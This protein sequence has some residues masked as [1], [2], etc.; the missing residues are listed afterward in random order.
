MTPKT[1]TCD[2][3]KYPAFLVSILPYVTE[4]FGG[5]Q[6]IP[7]DQ[8]GNP[9]LLVEDFSDQFPDDK[10]DS[11]SNVLLPLT[12]KYHLESCWTAFGTRVFL[13]AHKHC[14]RVCVERYD[15]TAQ[16]GNKNSG[17]ALR[18]WDGA[19]PN[20]DCHPSLT[21]LISTIRKLR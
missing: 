9:N 2:P 15:D 19:H 14:V 18:M 3:H 10:D 21:D 11:W 16:P 8:E 1:Y 6:N 7:K 12:D 4:L 5:V 13:L 17:L 20:R